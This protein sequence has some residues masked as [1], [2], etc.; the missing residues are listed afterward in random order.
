V[1]E[2]LTALR[3]KIDQL[4]KDLLKMLSERADL[5]LQTAKLKREQQADASVFVPE[6]ELALITSLQDL[7][8]GPLTN[9][10][11]SEIFQTI[12]NNCR[13]LQGETDPDQKITFTI[14]VQGDQGSFSE[15]AALRFCRNKHLD[16]FSLDYRIT[17]QAVVTA[18]MNEQDDYGVLALNNTRGGLVFETIQALTEQHYR[19]VDMFPILVQ[20]NLMVLP[21]TLIEDIKD[22]HSHPQALKQSGK[23]LQAHLPNAKANEY[24]DTAQA[25]RYLSEGKLSA[26]S[27]VIGNKLCAEHYGLEVLAE[28]I[29]DLTDNHTLFLI[30]KKADY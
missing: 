28:S 19:I 27:A 21:G 23:F 4:D 12:V 8:K 13:N 14:A 9:D 11:V 26:D 2:A 20:Q 6:R 22:V 15:Q 7:N 29:Q 24:V 16:N 17:S 10:M 5:A 30:I 1:S 18:V 3:G 25:A